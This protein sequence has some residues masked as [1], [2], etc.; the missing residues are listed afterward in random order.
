MCWA[1]ALNVL[2]DNERMTYTIVAPRNRWQRVE[3]TGEFWREYAARRSD[4]QLRVILLPAD[5]LT[6]GTVAA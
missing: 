2:V 5:D 3:R 6:P 4:G 1:T